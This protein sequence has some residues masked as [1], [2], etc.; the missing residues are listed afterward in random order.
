MSHNE[1][2]SWL[3]WSVDLILPGLSVGLM[4][5]YSG[6]LAPLNGLTTVQSVLIFRARW[7]PWLIY[8]GRV[9]RFNQRPLDSCGD[10]LL[11]LHTT[12]HPD[13]WLIKLTQRENGG[14]KGWNI[15]PISYILLL[16]H[17]T[18]LV[19][20]FY[21]LYVKCVLSLFVRT[22]ICLLLHKN[23][24]YKSVVEVYMLVNWLG[25]HSAVFSWGT[26]CSKMQTIQPHLNDCSILT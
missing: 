15:C 5:Q 13:H 16:F 24:I 8:C 20:T 6:L 7:R 18:S 10:N 26:W 14:F 1:A 4:S 21:F 9:S 25:V 12:T 3:Q 11:S 23:A 17:E 22:I 19:F 2:V